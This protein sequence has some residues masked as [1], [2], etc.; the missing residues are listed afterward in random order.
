[1]GANE[2]AA[3]DRARDAY[4]VPRRYWPAGPSATVKETADK[5]YIQ[6]GD[7]LIDATRNPFHLRYCAADGRPFLE[8]VEEGGLSWS[9]WDYILHTPLCACTRGSFLRDWG[10]LA[11][12]PLKMSHPR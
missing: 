11:I 1:M 4:A 8:E 3:L 10:K 7:I 9:Y 2:L 6:A 5:V 12:T